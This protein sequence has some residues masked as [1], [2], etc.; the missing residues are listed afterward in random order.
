M[1]MWTW[2][3]PAP[4]F[5][6]TWISAQMWLCPASVQGSECSHLYLLWHHR[7]HA[8]LQ[9]E[10]CEDLSCVPQTGD[11]HACDWV[12]RTWVPGTSDWQALLSMW[13]WR[14]GIPPQTDSISPWRTHC[15]LYLFQAQVS[16]KGRLDPFFWVTPSWF[17]DA[18]TVL[19]S[20]SVLLLEGNLIL[21]W[22]LRLSSE[23]SYSYLS[24]IR[25]FFF[26][27]KKKRTQFGLHL[28]RTIVITVI[29]CHSST[30]FCCYLC[31]DY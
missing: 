15:L 21:T 20:C 12:G 11:S 18:L 6:W 3:A 28:Q 25:L 22:R 31:L 5:R 24:L 8:E 29:W 1:S 7:Q 2:L 19:S 26:V 9:R 23:Y 17:L 4:A 16:R 27:F 10:G 30:A 14:N 13:S